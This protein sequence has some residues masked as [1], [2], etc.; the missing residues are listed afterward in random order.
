MEGSDLYLN[1]YIRVSFWLWGGGLVCVATIVI[2]RCLH[3]LSGVL[4][5]ILGGMPLP[6]YLIVDV[7]SSHVA[8]QVHVVE[9]ALIHLIC[10]PS[11][12]IYLLQPLDFPWCKQLMSVYGCVVN[13]PLLV[14]S[15]IDYLGIPSQTSQ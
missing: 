15:K 3:I 12:S 11:K 4:S 2:I 1:D 8:W 6:R 14:I 9:Y 10:L 5:H 13:G 7:Y